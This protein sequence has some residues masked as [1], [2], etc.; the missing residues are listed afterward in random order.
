MVDMTFL[1]GGSRHTIGRAQAIATVAILATFAWGGC[2]S[3]PVVE[4]VRTTAQLR[5]D[6]ATLEAHATTAASRAQTELPAD[7]AAMLAELADALATG[8]AA[9]DARRAIGEAALGPL[10]DVLRDAERWVV[11]TTGVEALPGPLATVSAW[12]I[13][14]DADGAPVAARHVVR[15][16]WP[17]GLAHHVPRARE[18]VGDRVLF[19][20]P[21]SRGAAPGGDDP[22]TLRAALSRTAARVET[23]PRNDVDPVRVRRA[24]ESDTVALLWFRGSADALRA[25]RPAYGAFP[26]V[27]AWSLPSVDTHA[28]PA[29]LPNTLASGGEGPA[30]VLASSWPVPETAI[31]RLAALWTDALARGAAADVALHLAV[32]TRWQEGAPPRDWAGQIVVGHAEDLAAPRRAPWVRRLLRGN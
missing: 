6:L 7:F 2:A 27:F 31:A 24:L 21:F 13:P 17:D 14:W 29:L 23:I 32:R 30:V 10:E 8:D 1:G 20:S 11:R 16:A 9:Q 22:D 4:D 26:A 19:V 15:T 18:S 25:L 12:T 5:I 28:A 3:D